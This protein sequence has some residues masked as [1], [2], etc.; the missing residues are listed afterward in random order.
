MNY[1]IIES[2]GEQ[3]GEFSLHP[4]DL[5]LNLTNGRV[6]VPEFPPTGYKAYW[7][8]QAWIRIPE[9]SSMF[10]KWDRTQKVWV[11]PRT[12]AE[13]LATQ[14]ASIKAKRDSI[15]TSSDWRVI[16]AADTGIPLAEN[17]KVYRQILRDIT[18]QSDPFNILWPVAPTS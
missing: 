5:E 6:V 15:L 9:K 8:G 17:W 2:D 16:K 11:D 3:V 4:E 7:S 18:T 14:W 10:E 12:E 1:Y 13:K